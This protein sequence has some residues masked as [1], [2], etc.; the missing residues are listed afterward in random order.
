[1]QSEETDSDDEPSSMFEVNMPGVMTCDEVQRQVNLDKTRI[2]LRESIV[3]AEV[4]ASQA[5]AV[6]RSH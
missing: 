5:V 2:R 4:G 6:L 3:R 1:M